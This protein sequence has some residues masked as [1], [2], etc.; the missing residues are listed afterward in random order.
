MLVGIIVV[1]LLVVALVW[2]FI[3]GADTRGTTTY[4]Q[5]LEDRSQLEAIQ[6]WNQKRQK[7]KQEKQKRKKRP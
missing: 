6:T 1:E 5:E 4:E 7:R 2:G 3:Y